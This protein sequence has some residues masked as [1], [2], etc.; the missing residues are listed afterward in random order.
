MFSKIIGAKRVPEIICVLYVN[1]LHENYGVK[2]RLLTNYDS[3][4][5]ALLIGASG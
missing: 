1:S 3:T 4:T 5:L 2:G